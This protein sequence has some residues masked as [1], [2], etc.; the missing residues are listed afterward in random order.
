ME[1]LAGAIA[2]HLKTRNIDVVLVGG[3]VAFLFVKCTQIIERNGSA[4]TIA[5]RTIDAYLS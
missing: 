2:A 5:L 1:Q 3:L 4:D